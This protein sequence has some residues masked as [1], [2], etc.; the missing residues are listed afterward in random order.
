VSFLFP[1]AWFLGLLS[2]PVIGLY[3]LKTR[4]R[5]RP[6][7]TLL[8]W[9]QLRPKIENSPLWRK[10][11]KWLSLALQL[12][13][14][15]LI[16]VALARPAFEWEQLQP[17]RTVLILDPSASMAATP[18]GRSNWEAS[19][20][21]ASAAID[22]L[23]LQDEAALLLAGDS[24]QILSGWTSSKRALR[25]ALGE[26]ELLQGGSDPLRTLALAQEL[27]SLRENSRIV[28]LS[29]LVWSAKP[30]SDA[31]ERVEIRKPSESDPSNAGITLFAVRRSP[32][33]PGDWQLD[34][35]LVWQG[36]EPAKGKLELTRDGILL[37]A[38]PV[39]LNPGETFRKSWHGSTEGAAAFDAKL[40]VEGRDELASD[41]EA[42]ASLAALR[43]VRVLL[44]GPSDP[45]IEAALDAI[46]LVEWASAER[47]PELEPENIDF[48]IVQGA[49]PPAEP[50]ERAALLM[51]GPRESGFWGEYDGEVT[52]T[53]ITDVN[54]RVKVARHADWRQVAL[55]SVGEWKPAPD[56]DVLAASFGNPA[57]FGRWD[58]AP[59]W[60]VIGFDP[61]QSDFLFRTAFPVFLANLVQSVRDGE[62]ESA[63]AA[64]LPGETESLLAS[65]EISTEAEKVQSAR[66]LPIFPGWWIVLFVA[67]LVVVTEWFFY[68]RRVTE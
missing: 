27:Q 45:F 57:V 51:I 26:A 24:P 31:L 7:S 66:L 16:V 22:Q 42:S 12:L 46:P 68:T 14:L 13:I 19:L 59:R 52:D 58:R 15:A 21:E 64:L 23:R 5:R 25:R 36:T 44:V 30:E 48:I 18:G 53:P 41:N 8:F 63:T 33:A 35:D 32:L 1:L 34:A 39:Q 10:L 61:Q 60:M 40:T 38:L 28:L 49:T 9:E 56:A 2:L 11:R 29:D 67:L 55:D 43:P 47:M 3:L 6:V 54:D 4:R 20:A 37:D 65:L 17:Q 50:L 62:D